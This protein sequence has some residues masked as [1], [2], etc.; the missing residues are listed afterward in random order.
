MVDISRIRSRK[1][2][3][4]RY[5]AGVWKPSSHQRQ[6]LDSRSPP[7]ASQGLRVSGGRSL[8][9]KQGYFFLAFFFFLARIFALF[10]L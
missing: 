5:C 7:H 2:A 9:V 4:R 1:C 6:G 3:Q 10:F 8:G